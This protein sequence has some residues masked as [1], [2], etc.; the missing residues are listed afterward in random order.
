MRLSIALLAG[1]L[2]STIAQATAAPAG[3]PQADPL[4]QQ[5][6]MLRDRAL[7]E[8]ETWRMVEDLTTEIGPRP[9]GSTAEARARQWAV[10]RLKALGFTNVHV[11]PF[12]I[13]R[14][15]RGEERLMVLGNSAQPMAITALG[16]SGAT[17]AQGIDAQVIGFD[18]L[19]A[20]KAAPDGSLKGKIAFITHRMART[21]D[22][23][24]YGAFG[25]VRWVGP[26]IAA[27]KGAIAT[28][29]RSVGTDHHRVPH[30]GSTSWKAGQ[31]P[32]PAGAL[33]V[34]DAEQMERLLA[35]GLV[36]VHLLLAPRRGGTAMSGNVIAD[37]PGRSRAGE[38][39]LAGGHLDSW[40]LGTGAIDDAAGIAVT[41]AA[42]K[43]IL[44]SGMHPE[45][46]IRIVFWGSEEI[47]DLGA[48]AYASAHAGDR[49]VLAGESDFGAGKIW[50]LGSHVAADALPEV[51]R[52]ARLLAP[53]GVAPADNDSRAGSDVGPLAQ[54]GVATISPRQD[55]RHYFDIH[56][57]ADD[58]LDKIDPAALN[59]NVATWATILWIAANSPAHF[60][61][62]PP[63][64]R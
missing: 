5:A 27:E 30:A 16:N 12:E 51:A 23:S 21:Q 37:I 2:F 54:A 50:A 8:N 63:A 59:Q 7:M 49:H 64:A 42:A 34:P 13:P 57:T 56:H 44:A 45:R 1:L 58:T 24:S 11:E 6:A 35:R 26:S 47:G 36:R 41:A 17:P 10:A 43:L 31:T 62:T 40:D 61:P 32:T 14:W 29:I 3:M 55:G 48:A 39:V 15:E 52:M 53:L 46:T 60:S 19:D 18:G 33:S 38:I 20:L 25:P 28:I 22:G 4:D 9:A